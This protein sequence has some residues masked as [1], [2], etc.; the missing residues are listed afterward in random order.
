MASDWSTV[1]APGIADG[2]RQPH[3][4]VRLRERQRLEQDAVHEAEHGRRRADAEREHEDDRRGEARGAPKAARREP[5]LGPGENIPAKCNCA[6]ASCARRIED[7]LS[8]HVR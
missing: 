7:L 4:A 3:E 6:W 5:K 8:K 1:A 2:M